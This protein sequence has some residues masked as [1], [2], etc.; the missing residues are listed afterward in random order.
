MSG[1]T[2]N[3]TA[4]RVSVV[5]PTYGRPDMLRRALDSVVAQTFADWELLIV[6][7]NGAGSETQ[8]ETEEVVRPLL[9]DPRI[10]Y[11]LHQWNRGGGAARNTG[12]HR[13][14]GPFVAFLDDD[15]A[16]YPRKLELQVARIE[17][18]GPEVALVH[19]GFRRVMA[20]GTTDVRLPVPGMDT[21]AELLKD[22]TIGTTSVALCR[23]EALLAIDG[24]DETLRSRQDVD[25]YLRLVRERRFDS[26]AEPLL[27]KHHHAGDAI[28]KNYANVVDAYGRCY[29]KYREDY[30]RDR[31]A[32]RSY[33]VSY[34]KEAIRAGEMAL[35][36]RLL[37]RAWSLAPW[38]VG[39]LGLAVVADARLLRA[40]RAGRRFLRRRKP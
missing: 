36:R 12:I 40:F 35:A 38:S 29:V 10:V 11:V 26:V 24:F 4:P 5:L 27:D 19:G 15:D 8:R 34:G 13:A 21:F 16:W 31:S 22:N 17:A 6:D 28:G 14:R 1:P 3:P 30:E 9:D 7:D 25:L 32:H 20:D 23:R 18:G 39:S 33:L 37:L 2:S